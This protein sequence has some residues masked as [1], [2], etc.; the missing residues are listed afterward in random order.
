[1][2]RSSNFLM[3]RKTSAHKSEE[4][5]QGTKSVLDVFGIN[6]TL[7]EQAPKPPM[8]A[9][10]DKP[11][12]SL[13]AESA[14]PAPSR[15][16]S[17]RRAAGATKLGL[18]DNDDDLLSGLDEGTSTLKNRPASASKSQAARTNLMTD[19]F[20]TS[21][22]SSEAP[23][24]EF[25]LDPK[26][27]VGAKQS[28]DSNPQPL[29]TPAIPVG[30]PDLGIAA[31]SSTDRPRR[32]GGPSTLPQTKPAPQAL[33][34]DDEK[35]FQGTSLAFKPQESQGRARQ[36][37]EAVAQPSAPP[38]SSVAPATQAPSWLQTGSQT[39]VSSNNTVSSS[40]PVKPVATTGCNQSGYESRVAKNIS[41]SSTTTAANGGN[42]APPASTIPA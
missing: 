20:G 40:N 1:M 7:K 8:S 25:E 2:T 28:P 36:S 26:Y 5:K 12:S 17:G 31:T 37:S 41:C 24:M 11:T 6:K 18:F 10:K 23:K 29:K 34:L 14:S 21:I 15:P 39:N 35:L 32:R 33:D 22:S 42:G 27:K 13:T 9:P 16:S 30:K 19:L 4:P 38:L 3:T